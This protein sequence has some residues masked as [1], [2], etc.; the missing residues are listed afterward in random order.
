MEPIANPLGPIMQISQVKNKKA[1]ATLPA[2]RMTPSHVVH[3]PKRASP[4][5]ENSCRLEVLIKA[6]QDITPNSRSK[7]NFGFEVK[8]NPNRK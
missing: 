8:F 7:V 1:V 4:G 3:I 2:T 6:N 5:R